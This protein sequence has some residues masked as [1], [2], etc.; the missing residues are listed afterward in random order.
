MGLHLDLR[1]RVVA[2]YEEK[3]GS[4]LERGKRFLVE[5]ATVSRW[6]KEALRAW[7]L[8]SEKPT[9]RKQV[10]R[11]PEVVLQSYTQ[12]PSLSQKEAAHHYEKQTGQP[13]SRRTIS[14][15][16]VRLGMSR[17]KRVSTPKN[18]NE[19]MEKGNGARFGNK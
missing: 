14:R 8:E 11:Y 9:G 13:I 18:K 5:F 4:C 6:A 12:T 15:T 7:S 1:K 19:R 17:K 2:V 10:L 3:E 16:L